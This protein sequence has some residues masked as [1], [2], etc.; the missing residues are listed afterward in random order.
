MELLG[1]AAGLS[2]NYDRIIYE[3]KFIVSACIGAGM[4]PANLIRRGLNVPQEKG[5]QVY[6]LPVSCN[7]SFGKKRHHAELGVGA[8]YQKGMYGVGHDYS[9]TLFGVIRIGYRYQKANGG[10][11]WKAGF[12]PFFRIKEYGKISVPFFVLPI[13]GI[14]FGYSI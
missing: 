6:G 3:K 7:I 12:T 9:K 8:T 4:V 14:G 5:I 2:V 10:F 11:F 13:A 1:N